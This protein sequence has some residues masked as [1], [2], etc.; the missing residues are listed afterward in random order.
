MCLLL[1]YD[2][3][4][5]EFG[6]IVDIVAFKDV[7][8]FSVQMFINELFHS[9]YNAF[10]NATQTFISFILSQNNHLI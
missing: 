1:V 8:F 4:S 6:R 7:T 2:N 9:L 5:P 3:M 10:I